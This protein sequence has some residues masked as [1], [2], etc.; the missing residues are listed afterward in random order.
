MVLVANGILVLW[1]LETWSFGALA[2]PEI[3]LRAALG[4]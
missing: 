2:G 4:I 1:S 3:Q